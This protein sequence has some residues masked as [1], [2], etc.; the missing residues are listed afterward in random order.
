MFNFKYKIWK[1]T[2]TPTS[3]S[4]SYCPIPLTSSSKP[5]KTSTPLAFSSIATFS[6][7]FPKKKNSRSVLKVTLMK[8]LKNSRTTRIMRNLSLLLSL[9]LKEGRK[10]LIFSWSPSSKGNYQSRYLRT[11]SNHTSPKNKQVLLKK[12]RRKFLKMMLSCFSR[13]QN[14]QSNQKSQRTKRGNW[15]LLT[16]ILLF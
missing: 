15:S 7:A 16:R 11:M 9:L 8:C 2:S 14:D 4:T 12:T 3:K 13:F 10:A 6:A 1:F 5:Y